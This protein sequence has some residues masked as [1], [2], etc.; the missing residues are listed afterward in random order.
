MKIVQKSTV[1]K[2]VSV[3]GASAPCGPSRVRLGERWG[4]QV[5]SHPNPNVS[6]WLV[7]VMYSG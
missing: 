5:R 7:A 4:A 1:C 3:A 6:R 2:M